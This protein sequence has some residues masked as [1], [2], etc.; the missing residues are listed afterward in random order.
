MTDNVDVN[1]PDVIDNLAVVDENNNVV[2]GDKIGVVDETVQHYI[3]SS[4][5]FVSWSCFFILMPV[6]L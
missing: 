6:A 4:K 3:E 2:A 5:D 1:L